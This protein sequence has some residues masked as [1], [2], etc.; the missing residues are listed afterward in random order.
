VK[1]A[2][3]LSYCRRP[4]DVFTDK[5]RFWDAGSTGLVQPCDE[6]IHGYTCSSSPGW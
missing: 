3:E 2:A 6:M 1:P 4:I 5:K